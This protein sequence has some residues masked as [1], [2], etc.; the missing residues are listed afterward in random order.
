[1]RDAVQTKN[2]KG[3]GPISSMNRK[4]GAVAVLLLLLLLPLGQVNA[5]SG[6]RFNSA[7]GCGCH[8]GAGGVTAQLNGLPTAY[9]ALTTYGLTVSMSTSPGTGGFNLDANRG[10][11][12][13]GDANTQVAS[14]GRQATHA[15]APGT[16]SWTMDWTAP[17]S[18]SG[19]VLFKLAVLSGNGNGRTSGDGYDTISISVAEEVS[20]NADPIASN[21]LITPSTPDTT[22]D[23]TVSYTYSDDDG[24]AESGTTVA[25]FKDGASQPAHTALIL[26]STATSKGEAWYAVITPSDGEDDGAPVASP[27]VNVLNRA[28]D[29]LNL[30]VSDEAP[31][32][33]DDVSFSFQTNDED[34]DA[35]AFTESRWLLDDVHVGS[36]D[37]SSTLPA[38]ATRAGDTWVVEVRAA[39]ATDIGEWVSSA[40]VVVGTSNQAPAITDLTVMPTTPNTGDSL[41]VS[42]TATDP[43]GDEIVDT[44]L[45]WALNG[46]HV[47]AADGLNPLP[48]SFTQRGDAWTVDVQ[49]SDGQAWG[50]SAATSV[51][52]VNAAPVVDA[53][54]ASPTFSARHD[55]TVAANITDPDG[56][57]TVVE[58]VDWYRN[59]EFEPVSTSETLPST[60]L[61]RGDVWHAVVVVSDGT[62]S[63]EFTTPAITVENA[64]P[65][66]VVTWPENPTSLTDLIATIETQDAD[67][68]AVVV[69]TTWYKN[70]FRDASL[71]NA[72][73]VQADRLA[74]EQ[75]WRLVVVAS[76]GTESSDSIESTI[77]LVNLEPMATIQLLSSN[78][79]YNETTVLS[80]AASA[81][82]DGT[83][84]RY[85]WT[86][87]TGSSTGET[88]ALVL[89][90]NTVVTL[91][92]TD[93]HGATHQTDLSLDIAIGPDV[94]NLQ[95]I[96]DDRGNV[97]LSWSWTGEQAAFNILRNGVLVGSTNA[98]DY[99]DQP[100]IS[101]RVTYTVQPFDEERTYLGASD[102]ISPM[103]DPIRAEEPGPATGL[104]LGLGALLILSLLVL[105]MLGR[106][107]G[108]RR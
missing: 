98:T 7:N 61:N 63:T 90:E 50:A 92:I 5:N 52:I 58:R 21:V 75:T 89:K 25:W 60:N 32:T 41:T 88:L 74:P 38:I 15:Y 45:T 35:I 36:L 2:E 16:T 70:G 40:D 76:D 57:E 20:T 108:E 27:T 69:S 31:D 84:L 107:G 34:G 97:R 24:D 48:P 72:T 96:N 9:E 95:V 93:E 62:D 49:A 22:D 104:G 67:G 71:T 99:E 105:P 59:G 87:A 103:L 3:K 53:L 81:D 65:E 55:V 51:N 11:L 68:D 23:L 39:D 102:S 10:T 56:D 13:N 47:P 28:P 80:G 14:N 33:N 37:N 4:T 6:G 78:V 30:V 43:E 100:P 79:W 85:D 54:L 1:M 77:T 66:A 18:G 64:R 73:V 101:G 83:D 94:R 8:G 29:V 46:E 17:S 12:S 42:W 106:R 26:P 82:P 19:S 86:W 91:T 44:M